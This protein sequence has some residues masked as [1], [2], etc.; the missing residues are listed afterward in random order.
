MQIRLLIRKTP[1]KLL[2]TRSKRRS[3]R[4]ECK[5]KWPSST[6]TR[7]YNSIN[8]CKSGKVSWKSVASRLTSSKINCVLSSNRM[9]SE[10]R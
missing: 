4:R 8:R 7:L 9:V 10:Y 2:P 3:C 5:P 6:R 1:T